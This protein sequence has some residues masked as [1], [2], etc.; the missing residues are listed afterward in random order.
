MVIEIERKGDIV[1]EFSLDF[2]SD[3][4][5][6]LGRELPKTVQRLLAPIS[7]ELYH[8]VEKERNEGLVR[9]SRAFFLN[10]YSPELEETYQTLIGILREEDLAGSLYSQRQIGVLLLADSLIYQT[11]LPP[12]RRWPVIMQ[13]NQHGATGAKVMAEDVKALEASNQKQN[14]VSDARASLA[15]ATQSIAEKLLETMRQDPR[16]AEEARLQLGISNGFSVIINSL[17]Y[18]FCEEWE[19]PES[20]KWVQALKARTNN[21]VVSPFVWQFLLEGDMKEVDKVM[22]LNAWLAPWGRETNFYTNLASYFLTHPQLQKDFWGLFSD[23]TFFRGIRKE[24]GDEIGDEDPE[25][26]SIFSIFEWYFLQDEQTIREFFSTIPEA[27]NAKSLQAFMRRLIG[28]SSSFRDTFPD[29]SNGRFIVQRLRELARVHNLEERVVNELAVLEDTQLGL[30]YLNQDMEARAKSPIGLESKDEFIA[31]AEKEGGTVAYVSRAD[32]PTPEVSPTKPLVEEGLRIE[33]SQGEFFSRWGEV[34][35][36][37]DTDLPALFD[38]LNSSLVARHSL[39]ESRALAIFEDHQKDASRQTEGHLFAVIP[40]ILPTG[41]N[42][43]F[44]KEAGIIAVEHRNN[45]VLVLLDCRRAQIQ[46]VDL[47][48]IAFSGQLD[49]DNWLRFP[50]CEDKFFLPFHLLLNSAAVLGKRGFTQ[51]TLSKDEI[52]EI[53]GRVKSYNNGVKER[54]LPFELRFDE[55]HSNLLPNV[56]TFVGS[57]KNQKQVS[58]TISFR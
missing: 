45:D 3:Y 22:I 20:K 14:V 54:G 36:P 5:R 11:A 7:L 17:F 31:R 26:V 2:D 32:W 38:W 18:E 44:L 21:L 9:F 34:L 53:R 8:S 35:V 48:M 25:T 46:R 37:R 50:G 57:G 40:E 47:S 28:I 43:N 12:S 39:D 10:Q 4:L 27:G 52:S 51:I 16:T 19:S 29:H 42:L 58:L 23:A 30:I 15:E 49:Q 13:R 6:Y 55:N 33:S 24:G 41:H 56:L 1:P